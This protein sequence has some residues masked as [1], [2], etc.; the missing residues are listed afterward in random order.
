VV[1]AKK[2]HLSIS[3][4]EKFWLCPESYRRSYVNRERMPPNLAMMV[5]SASHKGAEVNFRQKIETYQDLAVDEI[6]EAS[7][8][9]FDMAT[10]DLYW[11]TPEEVAR[12]ET[13]VLAEARDQVAALARLHAIQQ[14]P[15]YQPVL[16]E[17]WITIPLPDSPFDLLCVLDLVDDK[18]RLTDFK[19]SNKKMK[20]AQADRSLQLTTYTAAHYVK[21]G[22][23]PSEVRLDVIVKGLK[24]QR[25]LLPSTRNMQDIA[26]LASRMNVTIAAIQAG[27]FTPCSPGAWNCSDRWC[28]YWSTCPYVN[29]ERL[30]ASEGDES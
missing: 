8:E 25:Q 2:P 22:C 26:V 20:Q 23:L 11:L 12:G 18:A 21:F 28:N 30:A 9:A 1:Q 14:A 16:V 19:T 13:L 27:I 3:A 15:C 24:P 17:E 4:M 5:G 10:K 6:V 7:V 29:A